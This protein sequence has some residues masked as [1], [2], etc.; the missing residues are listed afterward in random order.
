MEH[1]PASGDHNRISIDID[2][3]DEI[4][5]LTSK[6]VELMNQVDYLLGVVQEHGI[7]IDPKYGERPPV[8]INEWSEDNISLLTAW[9]EQTTKNLFV[10]EY[11]L[12]KYRTKLNKWLTL[13]LICTSISALLA[14]VS[15]ALS[16]VGTY[17]WV[18]FGFNIA[19]LVVSGLGSFVNGYINMEKWPDLVTAISGYCVKMNSFLC[20]I[21]SQAILPLTL[22]QKGDDFIVKE[23]NTYTNIIQ[24]PPQISLSDYLEGADKFN[25]ITKEHRPIKYN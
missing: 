6:N 15:S 1:Q 18:V 8:V 21:K 9:D 25:L 7:V 10:Y 2:D 23:N 22:R 5:V 4:A 16:A 13:T 17:M 3:N 14:G 11:V 12:E 24:T 19:I 20:I